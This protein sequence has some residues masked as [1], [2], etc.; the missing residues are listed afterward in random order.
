MCVCVC[1][2]VC[3]CIHLYIYIHIYTCMY[4]YICIH[5]C[6]HAHILLCISIFDVY[7]HAYPR[8]AY[9][10][11]RRRRSRFRIF[12]HDRNLIYVHASPRCASTQSRRRRS[13]F[14]LTCVCPSATKVSLG[15]SVFFKSVP[16]P[17]ISSAP[18]PPLLSVLFASFI[19]S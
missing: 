13:K 10:Q 19:A 1:V 12:I 16:L 6:S 4:N 8:C 2:C 11:P 9:T 3:V 5:A 7:L 14:R 17:L 15:A 18:L